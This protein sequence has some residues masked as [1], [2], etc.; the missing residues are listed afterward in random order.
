MWEKPGCLFYDVQVDTVACPQSTEVATPLLASL[1]SQV[2]HLT[3]SDIMLLNIKTT[4]SCELPAVWLL[5]VCL[6]YILEQ[7]MSGKPR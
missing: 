3:I 7:R 5:L 4:E 6:I 1:S 2:D